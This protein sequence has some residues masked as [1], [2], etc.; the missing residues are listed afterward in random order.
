MASGFSIFLDL[1]MHSVLV[2]YFMQNTLFCL[3]KNLGLPGTQ[4]WWSIKRKLLFPDPAH[5]AGWW[6]GPAPAGRA[7][8]LA[9]PGWP[10]G[11]EG[12]GSLTCSQTSL[13]HCSLPLSTQVR[14]RFSALIL[15]L[16]SLHTRPI[17]ALPL[18]QK[19]LKVMLR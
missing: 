10:A 12:V 18:S 4:G 5:R 14:P 16:P 6:D 9:G 11:T 13:L 17:H 7:G 15:L 1:A 19:R 8:Q 2:K 3:F